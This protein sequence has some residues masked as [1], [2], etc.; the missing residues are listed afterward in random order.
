MDLLVELTPAGGTTGPVATSTAALAL[1]GAS[2][3]ANLTESAPTSP[4][5]YVLRVS[6]LGPYFLGTRV[7]Q[8]HGHEVGP[9]P[10]PLPEPD[11]RNARGATVGLFVMANR[12]HRQRP[13]AEGVAPIP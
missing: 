2:G 12:R 3:R 6:S 11:H 10:D 13:D 4:G 1:E 7:G 9:V 5:N 8:P